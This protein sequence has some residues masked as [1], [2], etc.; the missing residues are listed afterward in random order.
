MCPIVPTFTCGLLRS[1]FSFAI[2]CCASLV[3]S[4][5]NSD[6]A[7]ETSSAVSAP[8]LQP[9][10]S[11]TPAVE[12]DRKWSVPDKDFAHSVESDP[13]SRVCAL[14]ALS[15]SRVRGHHFPHSP[16]EVFDLI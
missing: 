3:H 13:R 7:V 14:P 8:L 16:E 1:N 2:S 15:P 4:F 9:W 12:P 11:R 10:T 6:K 5:S